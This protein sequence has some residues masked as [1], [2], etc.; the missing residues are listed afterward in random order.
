ME[1]EIFKILESA[2]SISPSAEFRERSRRLIFA[3]T[4]PKNA[5]IRESFFGNFKLG[6]TV[7]AASF[8]ILAIVGNYF[9]PKSKE[10]SLLANSRELLKEVENLD[11]KIQLGE[12]RYLDTSAKEIAALLKIIE[13]A[14]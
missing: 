3:S 9:Y 11:F 1:N 7:A 10:S 2:R 12:I 4:R 6:L 13:G 8:A 14:N 5:S